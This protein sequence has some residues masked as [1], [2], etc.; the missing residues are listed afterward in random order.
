MFHEGWPPLCAATSGANAD[1]LSHILCKELSRISRTLAH[2]S[3]KGKAMP[4]FV[5]A[6][7][8]A[9]AQR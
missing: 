4:V 6:P 1:W 7:D 9:T 2:V 8:N 5:G 3:Q